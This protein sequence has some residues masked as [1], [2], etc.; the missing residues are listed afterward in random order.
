MPPLEVEFSPRFRA[1]ARA[2]PKERRQQ[3]AQATEL[4]REAFGRPHLHGGLGIRRLQKD[5]F[6][7]RAGRDTR[8]IFRL[9]GGTAS[10]VLVGN[11]DEV[12]KFLKN[13]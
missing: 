5:Y 10:M 7:F 4:L 2:L 1:A 11:H 8:C 3:V 13:L 6:E 12:R 9:Q